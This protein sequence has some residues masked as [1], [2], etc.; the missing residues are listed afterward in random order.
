ML[1][2]KVL[3]FHIIISYL[4]LWMMAVWGTNYS[5]LLLFGFIF[6]NCVFLVKF[7]EFQP[8]MN[9]RIYYITKEKE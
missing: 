3:P 5:N 2:R 8:S 1:Y 7:I 9:G 4:V 6:S